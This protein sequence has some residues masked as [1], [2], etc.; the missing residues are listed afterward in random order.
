M[1][2]D[3][4]VRAPRLPRP[5]ETITGTEHF[6]GPG[7]KGANQAVAVA[8]MGMSVAMVGR[9]GDDEHGETLVRGLEHENVDVSSVD[10]DPRAATGIAVITI[11]DEAENTIV[12]SPGANSELGPEHIEANR[13][14]ISGA[15]VVL[16]QLEVPTETVLAAAR[17]VTGVFCLNPAPASPMPEEL[18]QRTDVL[19]P[20]RSELGVLAG[21]EEPRT[22]GEAVEAVA[23]LGREGP[24]REDRRAPGSLMRT[25]Q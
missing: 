17:I 22:A 11:D 1:N 16:A 3:I 10:M 21:V 2:R 24:M 13:E 5:G 25:E 8:R 4:S 19:V 6:F 7:G 14:L 9:V 12:I 18:L 23:R 20:N 15:G